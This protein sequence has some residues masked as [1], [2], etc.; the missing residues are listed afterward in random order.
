MYL[1]GVISASRANISEK[2]EQE[3]N[4]TN[5]DLG[6]HFSSQSD[7]CRRTDRRLDLI[8]LN[9]LQQDYL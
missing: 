5:N 4:E 7:A 8:I 9:M 2:Y 6:D 1:V 3:A